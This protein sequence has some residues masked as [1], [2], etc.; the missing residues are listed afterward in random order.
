MPQDIEMQTDAEPAD[1]IPSDE[2]P[3]TTEDAV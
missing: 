3:S 2:N 1:A